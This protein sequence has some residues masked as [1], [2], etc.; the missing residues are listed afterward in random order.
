MRDPCE[1]VYH[2][3][4]ESGLPGFCSVDWGRIFPDLPTLPGEPKLKISTWK[5]LPNIASLHA[6]SS[7]GAT[8]LQT[9]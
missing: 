6:S 5:T 1:G 3:P 7:L 4:R 2:R 8:E 9:L